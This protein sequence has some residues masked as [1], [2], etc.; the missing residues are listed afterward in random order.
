MKRKRKQFFGW[1]QTIFLRPM[2]DTVSQKFPAL[3]PSSSFPL[4]SFL[5]FDKT[6]PH[7]LSQSFLYFRVPCGGRKNPQDSR[8]SCIHRIVNR[9]SRSISSASNSFLNG[10]PIS[11]NSSRLRVTQFNYHCGI[12]NNLF[13][14]S[15][16]LIA[17]WTFARG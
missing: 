11:R 2:E 3:P 13:C 5:D 17:H 12:K 1:L 9:P 15:A 6:S 7:I 4:A 10:F 14:V 8:A 16:N